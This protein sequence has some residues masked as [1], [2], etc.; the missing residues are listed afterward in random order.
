MGICNNHHLSQWKTIKSFKSRW[1]M[2]DP[3]TFVNGKLYWIANSDTELKCG[4]DIAFF[5]LATEEYG[6]LEMPS[7]VKSGFYSRLGVSQ[8]CLFVMCCHA[9]SADV[10]IM[11]GSGIWTNVVSIPCVDDFMRYNYKKALYVTE[12]GEV[13][14]ICGSKIVIFDAKACSFRYPEMR[15]AG[16]L[17]AASAYFESLVSPL[18]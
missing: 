17:F 1:L 12:N 4:W 10:W 14:L 6:F 16:E 11:N 15:N 13:L 18:G 3:A 8:G 2:D 5:D 7:Y 9:M